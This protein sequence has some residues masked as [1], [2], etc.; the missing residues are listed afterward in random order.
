MTAWQRLA[1]LSSLLTGTAWQRLIN[2]KTTGTGLVVSDGI[3]VEMDA[4]TFE[5]DLEDQAAAVEVAADEIA[6]ELNDE[7]IT[8]E[9]EE[10]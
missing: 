4:M 5:I 1:A 9:V 3:D 10:W 7:T 8:V 6:M 2:P